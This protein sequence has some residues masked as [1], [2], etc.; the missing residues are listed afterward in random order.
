MSR[1]DPF[2][3]LAAQQRAIVRAGIEQAALRVAAS[4]LA[5]PELSRDERIRRSTEHLESAGARLDRLD[6]GAPTPPE[7]E[8]EPIDWHARRWPAGVDSPS[9]VKLWAIDPF[10]ADGSCRLHDVIDCEVCARHA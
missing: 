4:L 5:D 8:K 9:G 1:R 7:P 2:A 6:A 10:R 3:V